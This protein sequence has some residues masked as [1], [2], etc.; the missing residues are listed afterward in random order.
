MRLT[1][2]TD[3]WEPQINGVVTTLQKT[4]LEMEA[5]GCEVTVLHP[6]LFRTVPLP[7]YP[8][9]RLT[10]NP[11]AFWRLLAASS[12]DSLHI[13]TEGPLG[14]YAKL[15]ADWR[16]L[17]YTTSYHTRFPEYLAS[18]L[19]VSTKIGYAVM[20]WFHGRSSAIFANTPSMRRDL[21]ARG[22]KRLW[23]WSRG[24]DTAVYHPYGPHSIEM[25][26]MERPIWLNVGRVA[27]EKNLT[28]FY[29][30]PVPGTKIQV[31]DGPA[32]IALRQ[33]YPD[34]HFVGARSG[35]ALAACYR[36]ADVFVFPSKS[37]TFGLVML[38]SIAS[39]VPVAAYPVTGPNDVVRDYITGY[40]D[41]DLTRAAL[42][43]LDLKK[44]DWIMT[45]LHQDAS[46]QSWSACT[47]QF[48]SGLVSVR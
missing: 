31:G 40:L 39:G 1:L 42:N 13:S 46:K 10:W 17:H 26:H 3:A 16:G 45:M 20:R 23:L 11:L 15:W 43:C 9:I 19:P 34:V 4:V 44:H 48:I 8:E 18:R 38:E 30:L 41:H 12:P 27:V 25:E 29:E 32:L 37:D 35:D 14:L 21:E 24:V 2:V 47:D 28:A 6:G 22:F 36:S 33:R 5:R 7:S